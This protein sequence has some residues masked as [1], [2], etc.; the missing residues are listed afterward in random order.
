MA[1]HISL[2]AGKVPLVTC[3]PWPN[4]S[5]SSAWLAACV[6]AKNEETVLDAGCGGGAVGLC[7]LQRMTHTHVTFVDVVPQLVATTQ[8][9]IAANNRTEQARAQQGDILNLP[10]ATAFNHTVANPPFYNRQRQPG[11]PHAAVEQAHGA[12]ENTL[13]HWLNALLSHTQKGGTCTLLTH[14][15]Q[16]DELLRLKAAPPA[17]CTLIHLQTHPTKAVKQF[18]LQ[19]QAGTPAAWEERVLPCYAA[20]INKA[21]LRDGSAAHS[22]ITNFS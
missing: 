2:L 5:S 20:E 14:A 3:P 1:E 6:P 11:S 19:I 8:T 16:Q 7:L 4:P 21:V 9:N 15:S 17:H 10:F 12:D 22:F 18:V 13:T